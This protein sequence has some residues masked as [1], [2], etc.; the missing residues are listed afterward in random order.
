[1]SCDSIAWADSAGDYNASLGSRRHA[2]IAE[3]YFEAG[4]DVAGSLRQIFLGKKAS[5]IPCSGTHAARRQ[6]ILG[7]A[8]QNY[9]LEHPPSSL[10]D[11]A[12]KRDSVF[13]LG[14]ESLYLP[15]P[16]NR[17]YA[18]RRTLFAMDY[19][20]PAGSFT[21]FQ[22]ALRRILQAGSCLRN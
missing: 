6:L 4:D 22:S 19:A 8:R 9:E 15:L 21:F 16:P 11:C 12:P 1:M 2:T 10:S 3:I 17:I 7:N 14:L 13:S 18:P 20:P 5:A